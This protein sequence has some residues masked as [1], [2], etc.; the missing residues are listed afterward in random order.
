MATQ[1]LRRELI[2]L[3]SESGYEEQVSS[4][5]EKL[6]AGHTKLPGAWLGRQFSRSHL[7]DIAETL[8]LPVTLAVVALGAGALHKSTQDVWHVAGW[9]AVIGSVAVVFGIFLLSAAASRRLYAARVIR[10]AYRMCGLGMLL[11]GSLLATL[12]WEVA[13]LPLLIL[14]LPGFLILVR[15]EQK[16][17]AK[18][19]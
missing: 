19:R 17:Q 4:F 5:R 14:V 13:P 9:E 15:F 10:N 2:D 11:G 18:N 1:G 6:Q 12:G 16:L 7:R 3:L 8:A